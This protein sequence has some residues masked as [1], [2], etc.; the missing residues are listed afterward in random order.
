METLLKLRRKAFTSVSTIG[1]LYY[2]GVYQCKIL[3]DMWRDPDNSGQLDADEKVYG[4]TAIPVG[5]YQLIFNY[6]TRF[7]TIMPKL[8]EVPHFRGIRIHAGNREVD[9]L[10]CLLIGSSMAKDVV[11]QSKDAY[12][13]LI[14]KL[15]LDCQEKRIFIE[16]VN[17]KGESFE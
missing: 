1:D 8:L 2:G 17:A 10:G 12:I 16:I 3:E 6:S 5:T 11:L 4:K 14:K 7:K 9:T 13:E 15:I